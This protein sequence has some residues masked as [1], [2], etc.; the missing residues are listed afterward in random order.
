MV[1]R[2]LLRLHASYVDATDTEWEVI[3]TLSENLPRR[4][5]FVYSQT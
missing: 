3:S 4:N 2:L 1:T 5:I